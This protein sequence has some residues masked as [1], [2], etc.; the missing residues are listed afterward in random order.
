MARKNLNQPIYY[1]YDIGLRYDRIFMF[2]ESACLICMQVINLINFIVVCIQVAFS[3]NTLDTRTRIFRER[4]HWWCG[5]L[6]RLVF[7]M[8][9]L[10]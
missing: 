5:K 8:F 2:R 1:Y 6:Y 9:A 3:E 4:E 10:P 7:E